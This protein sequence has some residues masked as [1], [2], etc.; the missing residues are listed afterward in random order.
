MLAAWF[1]SILENQ[2]T[3]VTNVL[4]YGNKFS[5]L[6]FHS[7]LVL[8]LLK[9]TAEVRSCYNLYNIDIKLLFFNIFFFES[10]YENIKKEMFRYSNL[11]SISSGAIILR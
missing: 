5:I 1:S 4:Y 7:Q 6:Y 3:V 10:E 9:P 11:F 8:L 2:D